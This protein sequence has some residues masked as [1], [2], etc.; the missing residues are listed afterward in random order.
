[1][2]HEFKEGDN[3][4]IGEQIVAALR[5]I[6]DVVDT[7]G[8][9]PVGTLVS[10]AGDSFTVRFPFVNKFF[11][12][13]LEKHQ[14]E[15]NIRKATETEAQE[16][17][18]KLRERLGLDASVPTTADYST[19][20]AKARPVGTKDGVPDHI[21]IAQWVISRFV[22]FKEYGIAQEL[23]RLSEQEAAV[24]R[25]YMEGEEWKN[26]NAEQPHA[27]NVELRGAEHSC[28]DTALR[29]VQQW[30]EKSM[31]NDG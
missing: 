2:S 14:W 15:A 6:C 20:G 17:V 16:Y 3:I 29:A 4:V 5:C 12:F 13:T 30:L 11:Q 21:G 9:S 24:R 26:Q 8:N 23:R 18:E 31:G 1:M 25:N 22:G 27:I 7:L 28:Y 19:I 10:L